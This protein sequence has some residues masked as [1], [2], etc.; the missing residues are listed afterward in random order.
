MRDHLLGLPVQDR[1]FV[2]VGA[3]P[4]AMLDAGFKPVGQD[5]PVF[6]H[7]QTHEEYA[8]ARTERKVAPG[9]SGFTFQSSP[10]VT[11]EQDLQRR[12]LT[13]NAIAQAEDGTLIDPYGGQADLRAGVFR[14]VSEAFA[15]DPVRILRVARFAARFASF[16]IAPP[17][18]ALMRTMVASGE[19]DALVPERVWQELSRGLMQT[20]PSRLFEVLI[21][22]GALAR[23][24]PEL[25]HG[26]EHWIKTLDRAAAA[27]ASLAVRFALWAHA[28]NYQTPLP[29]AES[30][31]TN[32]TTS[33]AVGQAS[34]AEALNAACQRLRVPSECRTLALLAIQ[35]SATITNASHATADEV[36]ALL[37]QADGFRKPQ[38]FEELLQL[39]RLQH[40]TAWPQ[41]DQR[42]ELAIDRLHRS[43]G[44][45]RAVDAARLAQAIGVEPS[46]SMLARG[47]VIKAAVHEARLHAIK[48]A[49]PAQPAMPDGGASASAGA[50]AGGAIAPPG[51]MRA[52]VKR[53]RFWKRLIQ[54]PFAIISALVLG[55]IDW[56]WTPLLNLM[57]RLGR[58]Q[59]F[60]QL[61]RLIAG[62]PP[63]AALL[64]FVV[65]ALLLLPF[66]ILGLYL[67]GHGQ[68]LAGMAV[69]MLAKV[70]GTALVARVFSLTAPTLMTLGWFS[71]L[72]K[73][74]K[75]YKTRLYELVFE[76]P[77]IRLIRRISRRWIEQV[78]G[79]FRRFWPRRK[80][81]S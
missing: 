62:L 7:P 67:I 75:S 33:P 53:K 13:I 32:P 22:C 2:V 43:L 49:A 70:L 64:V 73:Q 59:I 66:K 4:Q 44:A 8:L 3:S 57:M 29:I 45:A 58:F 21:D 26:S 37:S 34:A 23:L 71:R 52:T 41:K 12:D 20:R 15:E 63:Y 76:H 54:A 77:W 36:L 28:A 47:D 68:K 81:R 80:S 65:P 14:H 60:R 31:T 38:R 5:F 42:L 6:L 51:A 39:V 46:N 61:E 17:T 78:R 30:P 25:A 40:S 11:L 74:F 48:H 24:A 50:T 9:Y 35:H 1:D 10:E 69:F 27:E 72:Y 16:S 55:F 56:L 18:L 19:V 79:Q